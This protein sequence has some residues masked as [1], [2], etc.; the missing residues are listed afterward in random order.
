MTDEFVFD[1][2]DLAFGSKKPIRELHATFL[3]APREISES[4][5]VEIIKQYLPT[6]NVV[7][8]VAKEDYI[9]GF[10][11]QPQFKTQK[12]K[13]LQSVIDKVNKSKSPNKIYALHY[14]QRDIAYILEKLKFKH[15]LFVNG[16]WQHVFHSGEAYRSLI[17]N[18]MTYELIP[19]FT[20]D[21]EAKRYQRATDKK[22]QTLLDAMIGPKEASYSSHELL[23]LAKLSAIRSY[24]YSF[25]TGLTLAKKIPVKRDAYELIVY[26]FNE[27][28]PYQTYAMLHGSSREANFSPPNDLNH[29]D[30][31]HAEVRLILKALESERKQDELAGTTLFI[32]LMP[33]PACA[34]MLSQTSIKE[35]VYS[36]DHSEG[37]A[38]KLLEQAGKKVRRVVI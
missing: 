31:I 4:R 30:T 3:A 2:N 5:F 24:D 23:N 20:D 35:F 14:F 21:N 17:A 18:G 29:Y 6:G 19:A 25:Q 22:I 11:N 13:K 16:S 33:C 37:Y 27:V 9:L 32:N 8:G 38:V 12:I 10:E 36:F 26:E 15:S 7:L 1:W 28:V 34:R